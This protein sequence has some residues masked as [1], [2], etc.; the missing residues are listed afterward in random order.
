[1][2]RRNFLS[3]LG[4]TTLAPM[5]LSPLVLAQSQ[6]LKITDIR[7]FRMK[8]GRET[9]MM[10]SAWAP[11]RSY[12]RRVGGGTV[13]EIT[14]DQG[15]TGIAPGMNPASVNQLKRLLVG[16]DPF[17]TETLGNQMRYTNGA[18][19]NWREV[20]AIEIAL[21]DII[22]KATGQPLYKL[23]GAAKDR[24][25]AYASMIQ[26]STPEERADMAVQ[27][28]EQ[29]WQGMK[30]RLHHLE[31]KEDIRTIEMVRN[32][33]GDDFT[34]M[35]DANQA[36]SSGVWQPGIQWDFTRALDT[37]RELK[38]MNVYW[39]EEPLRRYDFDGLA[40]L[41]RLVDIPLAGGENNQG[42][43]EFLWILE[44]G[45]Y[46]ILQPEILVTEGI[47]GLRAVA[48]LAQAH[49]KLVI[50]HHGGGQLGTV[51]QLQMIGTWPH[52]PWLELLHDPPVSPYTNAFAIM[53]NPPVVDAEGFVNLPQEPGLGVRLNPDFI[54]EI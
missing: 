29:G 41:N 51:A 8:V 46:D 3:R 53:E 44:K 6:R 5:L 24:V 30:I 9:G 43:Q 45:V 17:D 34:I 32:A 47:Q 22:G 16:Q 25:P 27:L 10:E 19:S 21:W 12:M 11:G 14:T 15:I 31:M 7:V 54:E 40:E 23:W 26:L 4:A 13:T 42:V 49:H 52:C 20:A 48:A 28:K 36:Q 18:A 2:D 50:P 33:V 1:M 38:R 39:L 37:A 35:T